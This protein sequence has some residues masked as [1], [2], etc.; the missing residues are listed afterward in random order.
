[1][2]PSTIDSPIWGMM[3]S[4]GMISFHT[5]PQFEARAGRKQ[6]IIYKREQEAGTRGGH[7][8]VGNGPRLTR[9]REF[10][11]N[12]RAGPSGRDRLRASSP[13]C[14]SFPRL[15]FFRHRTVGRRQSWFSN[16]PAQPA[17]VY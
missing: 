10:G 4:V 1:M 17:E 12:A 14:A 7:L 13:C 2:V 11:G 15:L 5:S 3:M 9:D 6:F 8:V 16:I